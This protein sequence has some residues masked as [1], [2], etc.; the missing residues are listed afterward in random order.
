[1]QVMQRLENE[2]RHRGEL[3][4]RLPDLI[5]LA[6]GVN[7]S[8]RLSQLQGRNMTDF[9][10]FQSTITQLLDRAQRLGPVCFVGMVPVD[11]SKM[12]FLECLYYNHA[13][14]HR[15]KEATRQICQSRQIP[16]LDLFDLWQSR[17]QVWCR[18]HI[19]TDGLHPNSSGYRAILQ[20]ILS[21]EPMLHLTHIAQLAGSLTS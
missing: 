9:E 6:V 16:Y 14:Q 7:D 5:I 18:S 21:W 12:P 2:F 13:D 20:D 3:R 8:A 17:G 15:Y 4:N 1:M 19:S 11:E 10:L